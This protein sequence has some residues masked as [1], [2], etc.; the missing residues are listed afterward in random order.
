[1]NKLMSVIIPSRN[2]THDMLRKTVRSI[3]DAPGT[4][5]ERVEILIRVHE[6][7][8]ERFFVAEELTKGV[9]SFIIGPT[10]N[11]YGSMGIFIDDLVKCASGTW[12]WLLEDDAYIEGDW[13]TP[14][15]TMP[16]DSV[17]NTQVYALGASRY[18]NGPGG[19][20]VGVII[21]TAIAK[22]L[23]PHCPPVDHLWLNAAKEK[24][25]KVRQMPG[26]VYFHDGRARG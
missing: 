5:K 12:C 10:L 1:M 6:D 16:E 13:F 11:G 14:M 23:I 26:T 20:C 8:P 9:G 2:G 7:D 24:G 18:Q 21:P 3:L 19:E 17:V 25:C 15:S 22:S 4:D